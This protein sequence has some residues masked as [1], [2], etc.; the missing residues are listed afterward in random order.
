MG[1]G[2]YTLVGL[3]GLFEVLEEIGLFCFGELGVSVGEKG[4]FFRWTVAVYSPVGGFFAGDLVDLL[5][6]QLGAVAAEMGV[7]GYT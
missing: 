3:L 2:V 4:A 6:G 1:W 5:G 7:G